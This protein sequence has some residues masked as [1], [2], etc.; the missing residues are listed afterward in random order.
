MI[1]IYNKNG[2]I[3]KEIDVDSLIRA[4]LR[5]AN[6]SGANLR[7]AD[8]IGADLIGANLRGAD[9]I[10]ITW[11]H[12]TIYITKGHVR[13]GCQSHTLEEWREFS[14]DQISDMDSTA[15]DFWKQN[16]ELIISLCER[17]EDKEANK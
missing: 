17:F 5:G 14:D 8:L 2:E 12:W 6:L 13:I 10:I 4:N 3:L 11:S 16:K 15:I 9:L 1:K 7:R